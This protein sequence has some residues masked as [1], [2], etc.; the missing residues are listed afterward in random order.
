MPGFDGFFGA[1][2]T[3]GVVVGVLVVVPVGNEVV[4][5]TGVVSGVER[6]TL[7]AGIGGGS[8]AG[9]LELEQPIVEATSTK[10][11]SATRRGRE[12]GATGCKT[13]S[14]TQNK[15]TPA[16]VLPFMLRG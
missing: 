1:V 9:S 14:R 16:V 10:A 4:V 5:V 12:N 2:A 3:A 11:K 8:L 15:R 13:E 6:L 7:V